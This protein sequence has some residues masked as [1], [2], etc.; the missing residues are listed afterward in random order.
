MMYQKL[1]KPSLDVLTASIAFVLAFP[2]F[3]ILVLVLAI[4]NQ[5]SPFFYQLRPGKHGQIFKIIKFKTMRDDTDSKG[6]LLSDAERLT[7]FG[8]IVR[9]TSLDEI[10]Q[11]LNVIKGD[12]SIVGPRPLLPAY[13]KLYSEKQHK[14]HI[15]KPGHYRMGS[16][17]W[18]KCY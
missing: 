9:K 15:V 4:V 1:I 2:I 16:S 14:R 18:Q 11:L 12:M 7:S 10:P 5:G 6:R 17:K 3:L 13:L 8:K